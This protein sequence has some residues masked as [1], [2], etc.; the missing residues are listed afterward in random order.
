[1]SIS[2]H[3]RAYLIVLSLIP[4]GMGAFAGDQGKVFAGEKQLRAH[5]S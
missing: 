3:L 2:H 4:F 5:G 1:M